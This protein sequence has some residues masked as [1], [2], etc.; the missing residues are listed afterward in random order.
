MAWDPEK[1][2]R[3]K[4]E[5]GISF[6]DVM[7]AIVEGNIIVVLK[8][9]NKERYIHQRVFV[10]NIDDYAYCIPFVEGD[11][12]MFLKTIYPSRKH[13]KKYIEKGVL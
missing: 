2:E 9:K 8:N 7:D 6:E 3:L 5:R 1:N 4:I 12:N 11:D 13:T 10:V